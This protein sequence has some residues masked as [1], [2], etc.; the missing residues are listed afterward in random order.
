MKQC[1]NESPENRP[2][3]KDLIQEIEYLLQGVSGYIELSTFSTES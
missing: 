2:S 3:F 1:W